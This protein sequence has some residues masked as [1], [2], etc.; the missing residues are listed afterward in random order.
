[1]EHTKSNN[2]NNKN[3]AP[4]CKILKAPRRST[5]ARALKYAIIL[6][7]YTLFL[8]Y[9]T[10]D[11][12][13]K[14]LEILNSN[15]GSVPIPF[16]EDYGN[17]LRE[18]SP[19]SILEPPESTFYIGKSF[20]CSNSIT[21]SNPPLHITGR[22]FAVYGTKFGF[23]SGNAGRA[24]NEKRL[25]ELASLIAKL[26]S[27]LHLDID[28]DE[29]E[30]PFSPIDYENFA[31]SLYK[32]NRDIGV[33][34]FISWGSGMNYRNREIVHDPTKYIL[35]FRELSDR[36]KSKTNLTALVWQPSISAF[37]ENNG[38]SDDS[39]IGAPQ[40]GRI[41]EYW[42]GSTY[43][44]WIGADVSGDF[45]EHPQ[46]SKML[47][48]FYKYFSLGHAIDRPFPLA[49]IN[50][51]CSGALSVSSENYSV[52]HKS[53][54]N[55]IMSHKYLGEHPH[56]KLIMPLESDTDLENKA[57]IPGSSIF[58]SN[59]RIALLG[60]R[61]EI[62]FI[63][64][65]MVNCRTKKTRANALSKLIYHAYHFLIGIAELADKCTVFVVDIFKHGAYRLI[66]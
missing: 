40:Y 38:Y 25:L 61:H 23:K 33:P 54:W 19:Y 56:V 35:S 30:F 36:I 10:R 28:I 18:Q 62:T 26:G 29:I 3:G 34:V 47:E 15:G 32:V 31:E 11:A 14:H 51:K 1:M 52:E 60:S 5:F 22:P 24:A 46:S 44:D 42:P 27:V 13:S 59:Q 39:E 49:I 2:A 48:Q 6:I 7:C 50:S 9:V 16:P 4:T 37:F 45:L 12:R 64:S 66:Q 63:C 58:D 57:D 8:C 21:S 17:C 53:F 20:N 41:L 65:G 55:L 43:V